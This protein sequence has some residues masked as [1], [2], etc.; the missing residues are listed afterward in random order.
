MANETSLEMKKLSPLQRAVLALRKKQSELDA[1]KSARTEPVAIIGMGCR[2]PGADG[3]DAYWRLL[4]D[5]VDAIGEVPSARWD[6]ERF[7]HPDP[8]VPGK[9]YT[10]EGGFVPEIDQ[11]DPVFF[12]IS[13]R[14]A[15]DMDPQQRLLLEVAW[16]ALEDAGQSPERLTDRSVGSFIGVTQMEYATLLLSGRLEDIGPYAVTGGGICFNAG[17]VSYVL[18]IQGP[19]FSMDT[20]CSSSLLAIHVACQS[21]RSGESEL[22]LAGGVNLNI[23]PGPMVALSRTRTLSPDGRCKTFDASADGYGRGE[24]CGV[25]VLKRLSDAMAD[26]DN[27]LALIRG[28]AVNH[29]GV[30]SG[31]TV[32]NELA[33]EKL[34]RRALENAGVT[35]AGVDYIEAH[36]TGTSLGDPIEVGA[37]GAVFAKDRS[38]GSPLV[39]G[40]AKTN[41]GHLEAAAGIAGLMKIVLSLQHEAIPAHLHFKTP[42]PH[43]DWDSL[44][45]RIPV[46]RQPWPRGNTARIAGVSSF[47][48]SGTNAHVVLE[49]APAMEESLPAG[50]ERSLQLLALSAQSEAALRQLADR[51]AA[52]LKIHPELSL[53]DVCFTAGAGRSHFDHRLAVIA[54]SP[55]EAREQLRSGGAITGRTGPEKPR[56]AFLFTG[57]GS[58]YIGMGRGL[59]ETEPL[60]R[61][62]LDRCDE[63]LRPLEVPL[64]DLL[65]ADDADPEALNRTL[66]TQP[67]L[68]SLEYALAELWRSW[69]VEP[70][71]VMGH[72]VGEYVAA[73]VA[74]VFGLEDG[75]KL[76]AAR[77]RLM[78][79]LCEPG[80][81]LALQVAEAEALSLIAPFGGELSLA[82]INGPLS[83]VVSGKPEAMAILSAT[84]AG[85]GVKAKPLS[86]SHAFHSAMM[87]PMLAEF[88]KVAASIAYAEPEITLCANVTGAMVADGGVFGAEYWVRHVREA[89]R[90]ASGVEAL[91]A[92]GIDTFLEVGPR[93]SLLGMARECL[94]EGVDD[95]RLG[96]LPSLREGQEDRL[97]LLRSLGQWYTRG[98][99]PDWQAA[100][101]GEIRRKAR[102]PTYPFQR[103][104]YW[105]DEARLARGRDQ[106]ESGHPLLGQR[107]ELADGDGKVRFQGRTG[108]LLAPWLADFRIFDA[109]VLPAA[110]YLEMALAAKIEF[111]Q[112]QD[113]AGAR[114]GAALRVTDIRLERAQVLPEEETITLQLVLSP[115]EPDFRIFSLGAGSRWTGHMAGRLAGDGEPEMPER[116]DREVLRAQCPTEVPV[117]D[118]Y[119]SCRERGLDYGPAFQGIRQLFRGEGAVLGELAL[120]KSL[121]GE[122]NKYR[123]HPALLDAAFQTPLALLA[124]S[125]ETWLP[126]TVAE[127]DLYRSGNRSIDRVWSFARVTGSDED[128]LTVDLSLFDEAGDP[129]ARA[130]GVAIGRVA[131]E[132]V[133]RNF[134]KQ[135]KE[136]YEVAWHEAPWRASE[137]EAA[138][139]SLAE[140]PGSWLILADGA[141]LGRELATGLEQ[142]GNRCVL[143]YAETAG[144]GEVSES[145]RAGVEAGVGGRGADSSPTYTLNPANPEGFQ[146]LFQD[147]F[148]PDAPPLQGIVYLWALD[149]PEDPECSAQILTQTQ[150][151]LCGGALHLLQ[152]VAGQEQ[153][154][155]LWLVTRN[156]VATGHEPESLNVAQAPLWGMG[157][158]IAMEHPDRWGGLIDGPAAVDLLTEIGAAGEEDQV[159]Y[160]NGKRHVARLLESKEAI[161]DDDGE[162]LAPPLRQDKSYLITGGLGALGLA[163]ARWMVAEG[164]RNLVLTGRRAPSEAANGILRELEAAGARVL[165]ASADVADGERMVALFREMADQMPPLAGIVHAAGVLDAETLAGQ[166]WERFRRAMAAKV[167]GSWH[168]HTLTRDLPLDFFVCFSSSS[169]LLGGRSM[170]SY[171]AANTF[172][173]ALAYLRQGLGLPGLAIDWGQWADDGMW[174][175]DERGDAG[176]MAEYTIP[177]E[178][179][180]RI[181]GA[182]MGGR[183]PARIGVMAG[184]LS[185]YLQKVYP[186]TIPPF[187]ESYGAAAGQSLHSGDF[188]KELAAVPPEKRRNYLLVHIR[189]EINA[190]LGFPPSQ[191]MD[192]GKGFTDI[193]MDSLMIV[194]ARGRLQASLGRPLVSTLL[195]D[196]STP[197]RLVNY[198]AD[199]VLGLESTEGA[200]ADTA[201]QTEQAGEM[202]DAIEQLSDQELTELIAGTLREQG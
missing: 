79:T 46:A 80:A 175:R 174:A 112:G 148:P 60:F 185:A 10:R 108:V 132:T 14:E 202:V 190:I 163:T 195:F 89:V 197:E 106:G 95:A 77:G 115:Q 178:K 156:A 2:F 140:A 200:S 113:S 87:E 155:R 51:F 173:D 119:R 110:A 16:E 72:S 90:F 100:T 50:A 45:F 74:G 164:A 123:L 34:I 78:Q 11:F 69:G 133:A 32:P 35:P 75:L 145:Q 181:L 76:I 92:E 143:A 61:Q 12:G 59:Y 42:N 68:F 55:E 9:V 97:L 22:A 56:T 63:I 151:H 17:R 40:S 15:V 43:I 152:S 6:I 125:A 93:P 142:A 44:P 64:L 101:G 131:P 134:K 154:A 37:L 124:P 23:T 183:R 109:I 157:R 25:V 96:W 182:L 107:L 176:A 7:Y 73:C 36:G 118:H 114:R 146:R 8:D 19:S 94:P 189:S 62:I 129:I 29:D 177:T 30:S 169:V 104:R 117:L 21:L 18:G 199:D 196:Y 71:A 149:A 85:R 138:M 99:A 180:M 137:R 165:V 162:P 26:R 136:L 57:Q 54:S 120:P 39:I 20:A 193:G 150:R 66:Y 159:A 41:F 98:G 82:A 126:S 161:T 167:E 91:L 122:I 88:E 172:L 84:L 192:P 52:H 70:E 144:W 135:P 130:G 103:S 186:V 139:T 158:V 170:G 27:V 141:G 116:A 49:E 86:V 83:V 160:R 187:L 67:A 168:L 179:G 1:I 188:L 48:I 3:P 31:F 128:T 184:N 102:L 147:A 47:G 198:L 111:F 81:M 191:S 58:Q 53:A 33:Q 4:R 201:R 121:T 65:Y 171:V 13:P 153:S 105:I 5:G 24:G 28:S 127:L 166:D 194:E 38:S